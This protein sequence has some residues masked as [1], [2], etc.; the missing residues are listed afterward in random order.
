M[1]RRNFLKML[2]SGALMAMVAPSVAEAFQSGKMSEEELY[3]L[4]R[5]GGQGIVSQEAVV[6]VKIPKGKG[7]RRRNRFAPNGETVTHYYRVTGESF[8]Q[9]TGESCMHAERIGK[10][11]PGHRVNS[12]GT[13]FDQT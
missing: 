2:A 4:L 12:D 11:I 5:D 9:R 10:F 7:L 1:D 13:P 6:L 8:L 3:N